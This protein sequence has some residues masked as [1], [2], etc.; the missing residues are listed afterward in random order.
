MIC[1]RC[2]AENDG[3]YCT[4]CGMNLS[5]PPTKQ[6]NTDSRRR[7]D[8]L[9][10]FINKAILIETAFCVLI[11]AICIFIGFYQGDSDLKIMGL[12]IAMMS[13]LAVLAVN[14]PIMIFI[15]AKR[16]RE[17]NSVDRTDKDR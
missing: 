5:E 7:I 3:M 9:Y 13:Y 1:S 16:K 17:K 4:R 14:T 10:K 15:R 11:G 6:K 2:G 8:F 12:V